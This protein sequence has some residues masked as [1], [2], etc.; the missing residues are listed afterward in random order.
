MQKRITFDA[1]QQKKGK[2]TN[3]VQ[4]LL[5]NSAFKT[6]LM[7]ILLVAATTFE[8][9]PIAHSKLA[10]QMAGLDICITGV[11][12][13][14]ATYKLAECIIKHRPDF[15]LQAGVAGAFPNSGFHPGDLVFVTS[16]LLGD[17]GVEDDNRFLDVFDIGLEEADGFPFQQ[18]Y[19]LNPLEGLAG[20]IDLPT[21]TGITV[22]MGSG[23]DLTAWMRSNKYQADVESMEGAALHYVCRQ[24]NMPFA[25]IR[26]I[27][28]LVQKRDKSTWQ[29]EKALKRL[30]D[31]LSTFLQKAITS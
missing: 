31:W 9:A 22:Q 20:K 12:M 8:I 7:N 14:A 16:E 19:I 25:Q 24:Q 5:F 1:L 10:T 29:M 26:S 3:K 23:S 27:S 30:N 2:L 28:N 21:A 6:L 18:K 13:M 4:C 15:V 11:G 17:L